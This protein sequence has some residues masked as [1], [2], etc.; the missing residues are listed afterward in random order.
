MALTGRHNIAM[1][2]STTTGT[3]TLTLTTAVPLCNTFALSGVVDGER[4]RFVITD[5]VAGREVSE[6]IYT[7]AG[8][9]LTRAT[10]LSSTNGG[11]KI[12]C[13]GRQTV[14][15]TRAAEDDQP[16][17]SYYGSAGDSITNTSTDTAITINTEWIDE[18]G[19]ASVAANAVT[20]AKKGWYMVNMCIIVSAAS[21]F[22]GRVTANASTWMPDTIARGYTTAMGI[23][24]DTIYVG[25][26]LVE[27]TTDAF[28]LGT[29]SVTNNLG[30]T[31]TATVIELTISKWGNK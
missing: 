17:A 19:L 22:N 6:G 24:L 20:I 30:A 29:V 23:Q 9:T 7:A 18:T 15:I 13:S 2:Y 21:D 26:V 28:S 10:V 5:P 16:F 11:S 14:A 12:D 1:M 31:I 4:L 8:L 27:A 25:P 3:G